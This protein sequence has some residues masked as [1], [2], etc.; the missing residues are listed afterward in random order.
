MHTSTIEINLSNECL[1]IS[2]LRQPHVPYQ[3]YFRSID[4]VCSIIRMLVVVLLDNK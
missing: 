4:Q 3:S 1:H 2:A